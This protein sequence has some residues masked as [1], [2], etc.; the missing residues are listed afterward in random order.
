MRRLAVFLAI[1]ILLP[2]AATS[3]DPERTVDISIERKIAT[4]DLG[5]NGGE[6]SPDG[7]KVLIF[8]EDGYAHL[9]SAENADDESTDIRLE[10]ETTKS[11]RAASWHPGGK[12]ALIVGYEGTV[13]R[14]NS[15][16]FALGEAEGS[17][18]MAGLNINAI[19]FTAGSSVAY[20]GTD[21][22]EIW[23]Y[24]ADTFT[25]LNDEP[26]SRITDIDC[27]KNKN[28]CVVGTLNN[29]IAIIDQSDTVNWISNSRQYTWVGIGCEDATMNSCT[30][31]A[32]GLKAISIE[33]DILD[34]SKSEIGMVNVFRSL[35]G[36]IISDGQGVDSSSIIALA[37][38]GMVRWNQYTTDSFLMFSNENATEED[39]LLGGDSY[40]VAWENSE[41]SGFLVTSQGRIVSFE[42]ASEVDDGGIP[43]ILVILVA[44]CV[45]GVF[46]GLIYWNSPW[47]QRKY[48][49]LF[50]RKKTGEQ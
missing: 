7:S 34:T 46:I 15:S 20:L 14:F 1:L 47:L 16:N 2:V 10:N 23:K 39:V 13:L 21:E 3:E 44:L 36:D 40:A 48:A 19:H 42:P 9:L 11:L 4:Y 27:L 32:S 24:Y 43:N 22:G 30:G 28:I 38:L 12:S 33:I 6:V 8:G 31:F 41:Y 26:E 49:N 35:G 37:P 29:G 25:L 18:S 45:P 5:I 17:S 50:N